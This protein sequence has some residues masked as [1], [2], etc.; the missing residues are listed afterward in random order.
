MSDKDKK[1]VKEQIAVFD[2]R[3]AE[4]VGGKFDK[5]LSSVV[6]VSAKVLPSYAE[7]VNKNFYISG[8]YY[9]LNEKAT[10]KLRKLYNL[11]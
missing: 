3:Q 2:L 6:R 8:R 5:K 10:E 7:N 11:G 1:E 4:K 9:E